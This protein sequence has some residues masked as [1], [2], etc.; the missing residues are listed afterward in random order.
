MPTIKEGLT[1]PISKFDDIYNVKHFIA[2]LE[3]V[4]RIVGRLPEDLR[5][6][7]H[8]SVELPDRKSVV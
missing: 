2:T 8:T 6:V 3:G 5:N 7:N 4:V 1:E